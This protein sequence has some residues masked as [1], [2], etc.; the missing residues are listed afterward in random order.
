MGIVEEVLLTMEMDDNED[1][2]VERNVKGDIHLHIGSIRVQ[3]SPAEFNEL[4][5][6]IINAHQKLIQYKNDI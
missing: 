3:L 2:I 6:A 5:Q 1:L 4:R